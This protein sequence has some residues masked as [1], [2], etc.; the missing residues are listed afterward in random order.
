[1]EK[2]LRSFIHEKFSLD[3]RVQI[4][5][6]GRRRD[7]QNGEK[8]EE[9]IKLLQ[10]NNIGNFVKL[11][12]GTNRYAF[13]LDGFVVK[14]ATDN[15]GKI[16]NLK[17]FKMAKRLFPHVAK[18]Y[19][20]SE[21][22]SILVAEYI[23]PFS[24]YA[25][26]IK[27]ADKIREI[28]NELS[29][30]YLLGDVGIS[31]NNY[32]NWGVRPGYDEPVCLDFAYVYDVSSDI[33]VCRECTS[34]PGILIPDKDYNML[35]CSKCN[36]S[37][38]FEDLRSMIGNDVHRHHIG[39]L[40]E[41]GYKLSESNVHMTLDAERSNYL[42]K[43][44]KIKK[45]HQEKPDEDI[46]EEEEMNN[47]INAI[48]SAIVEQRYRNGRG[49]TIK[50]QEA[51][52]AEAFEAE[53]STVET[54][55]DKESTIIEGKIITSNGNVGRVAFSGK[56]TNFDTEI[57][58]QN[59]VDNIDEENLDPSLIIALQNVYTS[60]GNGHAAISKISNKMFWDI[61][62]SNLFDEVKPYLKNKKLMPK[63]F[64]SAI[65][66]SI[67][68]S[69]GT[70][71]NCIEVKNV[72]NRDN[73]GT[74]S[75][76]V[77]PDI[78]TFASTITDDQL[79]TLIFI[80]RMYTD[81]DIT[82]LYSEHDGSIIDSYNCI[83][84]DCS[85]LPTNWAELFKTKLMQKIAIDENGFDI[86]INS[87]M[88]I[89]W[90]T[91]INEL[92]ES[93][94]D[95]LED[96]ERDIEEGLQELENDGTVY[97]YIEILFGDEYDTIRLMFN[98]DTGYNSIPFYTKLNEIELSKKDME[99]YNRGP[100]SIHWVWD[101]LRHITPDIK[102][103]TKDPEKWIVCNDPD[104]YTDEDDYETHFV[105]L[106][107]CALDGY[108]M[109]A[110]FFGGI[111]GYDKDNNIVNI[112]DPL[113][114]AK[115]NKLIN[116][117]FV[118]TP[119]SYHMRAVFNREDI[120]D[121]KEMERQVEEEED[122]FDDVSEEGSIE[123]YPKEDIEEN[124]EEENDDDIENSENDD[125]SDEGEEDSEDDDSDEEEL[126]DQEELSEQEKAALEIMSAK[127]ESTQK[128][129]D[130]G[131]IRGYL[132]EERRNKSVIRTFYYDENLIE[133]IEGEKGKKYLDIS[134]NASGMT[135][136]WN[137][138]NFVPDERSSQTEEV[139]NEV[140]DEV[141]DE[142]KVIRKSK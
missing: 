60:I 10:S 118:N 134:D 26:M 121:E 87:L 141:E 9:I 78:K 89:G 45:I 123:E 65:Q 126:D 73:D 131:Y 40:S 46:K 42:S 19:E 72:P 110:Y 129:K 119:L 109:G 136:R 22:G 49:I 21:N 133:K 7:I 33:F 17:E 2:I 62:S 1:M 37:K 138:R 71:L 80:S 23:Q 28:L 104:N 27:Y 96:I 97:I 125:N 58:D 52:S 59:E 113:I 107:G 127:E 76:W 67:W 51:V 85:G 137:G 142:L 15:D 122:D 81:K 48:A 74:H 69:L 38:K 29:A 90:V 108:L 24:S 36:C 25:E 70:Y 77:L 41:E 13:K 50:S 124:S 18:T 111:I 88:N 105:V 128:R 34:D 55:E 20:V 11:G 135:Y 115:I 102:F 16:D 132:K 75:E 130:D 61:R 99:I 4:E 44:K 32:A 39:D 6:I 101:W 3:I 116:A 82:K 100:K 86:I 95:T 30:V 103:M 92:E 35:Y 117:S 47:T 64:Y 66:S 43:V 57:N 120:I 79:W 83:Y 5:L 93:E 31:S 54:I 106:E 63:T 91:D 140:K 12:P 112:D 94:E 8:Q 114:Y 84:D 139:K 98:D 53:N 68:K 56:M 14:I